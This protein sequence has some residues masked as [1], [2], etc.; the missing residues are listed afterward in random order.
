[1]FALA[2]NFFAVHEMIRKAVYY[3]LSDWVRR[4]PLWALGITS[5]VAVILNLVAAFLYPL[6]RDLYSLILE[7][8]RNNL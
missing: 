2:G 3:R 7:Y 6:I 1:M 8:L 5:L 4:H